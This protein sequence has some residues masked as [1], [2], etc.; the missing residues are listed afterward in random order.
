MKKVLAFLLCLLLVLAMLPVVSFASSDD[1]DDDDSYYEKDGIE[2]S[3]TN[4]S[5]G[6]L[7]LLSWKYDELEDLAKELGATLNEILFTCEITDT[8]S[9]D[10]DIMFSLGDDYEEDEVTILYMHK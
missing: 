10:K 2:A 5:I 8:D 7:S 4:V 1:D 6:R 3:G 9:G